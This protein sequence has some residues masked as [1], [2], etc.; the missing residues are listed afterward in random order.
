MSFGHVVLDG[1]GSLRNLGSHK[2]NLTNN[3]LQSLS[4]VVAPNINITYCVHEVSV[5]PVQGLGRFFRPQKTRKIENIVR[6][7]D[8]ISAYKALYTKLYVD[9]S[10]DRQAN[11]R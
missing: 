2:R 11:N 1:G 9:I 4:G 5:K 7:L 10:R 3:L 6:I 8:R